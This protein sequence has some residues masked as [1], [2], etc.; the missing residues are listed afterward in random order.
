[1]RVIVFSM[2]FLVGLSVCIFS[3]KLIGFLCTTRII[4]CVHCFCSK[5]KGTYNGR[6]ERMKKNR[7]VYPIMVVIVPMAEVTLI[8]NHIPYPASIVYTNPVE[9]LPTP[10]Q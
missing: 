9:I 3:I 6:K 5:I 7:A 10:S 2:Y 4:P 1:M 8:A